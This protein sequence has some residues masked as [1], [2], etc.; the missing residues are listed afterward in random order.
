MTE[1]ALGFIRENEELESAY[2]HLISVKG[3]AET[4]AVALLGELLVL[5]KD[6]NVRQWVA[7]AGLD[8][9]EFSSG[10]SVRK[11][12]HISKVGNANIRRALYMPAL[13]AAQHEPRVKAYYE[14][15][16]ARGIA[17]QA[18]VVAV[19]RKLLHAIHGMFR[20]DTDFDGNKFFHP[21]NELKSQS[22]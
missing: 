10:T 6:M 18:A 9:R 13:V 19:M 1:A 16:Q 12:V 4:S 8:P 21:D 7:H 22:A 14:K 5:P 17:K 2:R 11:K 3:I 15:L 20:T